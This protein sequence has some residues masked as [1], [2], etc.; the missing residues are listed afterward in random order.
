MWG[1][2]RREML[3]QDWETDTQSPCGWLAGWWERILL[4]CLVFG[5]VTT[6]KSKGYG[7]RRNRWGLSLAE[8][9]RGG[10]LEGI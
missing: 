4:S 8:R 1:V 5:F 7:R 2:E 3:S 10:V 6:T 9:S